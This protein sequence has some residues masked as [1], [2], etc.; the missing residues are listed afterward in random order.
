MPKIEDNMPSL[1]APE[2]KMINLQEWEAFGGGGFGTFNKTVPSGTGTSFFE[3]YSV[4]AK[5]NS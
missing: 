4:S 1:N 2:A 5:S 3:S